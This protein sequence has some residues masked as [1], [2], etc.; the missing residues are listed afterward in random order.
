MST[1]HRRAQV[2][3]ALMSW[4]VGADRCVWPVASAPPLLRAPSFARAGSSAETGLMLLPTSMA[5]S[6]Y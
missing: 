3:A 2:T 5:S 4:Q 1:G 6:Y